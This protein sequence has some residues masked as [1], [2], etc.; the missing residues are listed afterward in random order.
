[1][2]KAG[3]SGCLLYFFNTVKG[4]HSTALLRIFVRTGFYS[5]EEQY[6]YCSGRK[7]FTRCNPLK[8]AAILPTATRLIDGRINV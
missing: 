3:N 1:M 4:F 2:P 5:E 7:A 8:G 6:P